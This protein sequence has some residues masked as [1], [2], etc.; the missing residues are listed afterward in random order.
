MP[1][2]KA[3]TSTKNHGF[4]SSSVLKVGVE[5][6]LLSLLFCF[7]PSL[8]SSSSGFHS[9][10]WEFLSRDLMCTLSFLVPQNSPATEN[11]VST[12]SSSSPL[13]TLRIESVVE[14]E[15]DSHIYAFS[16][17]EF[18]PYISEFLMGSMSN[19]DVCFITHHSSLQLPWVTACWQFCPVLLFSKDVAYTLDFE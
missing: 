8:F 11:V 5:D 1:I 7:L 12:F 13:Y 4:F 19:L 17:L 3:L 9:I 2:V 16:P 14:V 6:Y 10:A 18:L 15:G